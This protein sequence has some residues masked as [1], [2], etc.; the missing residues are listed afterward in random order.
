MAQDGRAGRDLIQVG[1]DYI[2]YINVNIAS[3]NWLTVGVSL[4][5]AI[6][7]I[8][9]AGT[10]VKLTADVTYKKLVEVGIIKNSETTLD[11]ATPINSEPSTSTNT[12]PLS[13]AKPEEAEIST[14]V[15][16][17][18]KSKKC[19][20]C[21]LSGADLSGADL[22]GADL[23]EAN[24]SRA[25][26]SGASLKDA[27]LSKAILEGTNLHS[28]E[29]INTDLSNAQLKGATLEKANLGLANLSN[30]NLWKVS[31]YSANLINTNLS[32]AD[33]RNTNLSFADFGNANLSGADLSNAFMHS[34]N[35]SGA[36]L[37][38]TDLRGT[39]KSNQWF[40]QQKGIDLCGA[41]M[42]DD[43]KQ[44]QQGC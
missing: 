40:E 20:Q 16:K 7:T 6:A 5:P 9:V 26:L 35:F 29:L 19:R 21:D 32:D 15:N 1:R 33:L 18:L 44:S 25:N 41:K 10:G 14:N 30:A 13:E 34:V 38:R 12:S 2:R 11:T 43:G 3:G 28:V 17:L 31:L 23:R 36:N 4:L 39:K 42:P 22:V 24:L 37:S 8:L 27:N